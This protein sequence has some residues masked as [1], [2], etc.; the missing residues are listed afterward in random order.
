MTKSKKLTSKSGITIP[1]DVRISAGFH[2]CMAVDVE[3]VPDGVIIRPHV[4][5]CHY[6]GSP[7]GLKRVLTYNVCPACR[8][9]MKK[10]LE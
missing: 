8:D 9:A 6:C 10:E 2:P 3:T 5:V 4:A 7:E 1:K